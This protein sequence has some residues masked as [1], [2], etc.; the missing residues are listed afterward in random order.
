[1]DKLFSVV[2]PIYKSGLYL[3]RCLDSIAKQ[4]YADTEI[5]LV[6]D[7][8]DEDV[9]KV[10]VDYVNKA[11]LGNIKLIEYP[12]K[13]VSAARNRGLENAIGEYVLFC[14]SDDRYLPGVFSFL[15]DFIHRENPDIA[16]FGAAV[17]NYREEY[18][19]KAIV[20]REVKYEH[21][22]PSA[23][24][25]ERGSRPYVW[26]CV[27]KS[28]FLKG[29]NLRFDEDV[30]LGEDQLFQFC[31]FPCAGKICFVPNIFYEYH[32]LQPN[33]TMPEYV[34][35]L[36]E[37]FPLHIKIADK[38]FTRFENSDVDMPTELSFWFFDFLFEDLLKLEKADFLIIKPLLGGFCRRHNFKF[39][40]RNMPFKYRL[41]YYA[42]QSNVVRAAFK[43]LNK[44]N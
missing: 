38:V 29:N 19:L 25:R 32:Y 35:K 43:R 14:D 13:G 30:T 12:H 8:A 41:K 37:K 44:V 27:Y 22:S 11:E 4:L 24:F 28:S 10:A 6:S 18:S 5:I 39:K 33:S 36:S 17:V 31:A 1:M 9:L 3:K 26:N 21:Y 7:G 2:I 34:N 15:S 40:L 20:P 23:L 16:V 42:L